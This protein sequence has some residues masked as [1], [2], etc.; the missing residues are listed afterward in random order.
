MTRREHLSR[1]GRRRGQ[2]ALLLPG[3]VPS[4]SLCGGVGRSIHAARRWSAWHRHVR[5]AG[6]VNSG[7][8]LALTSHCHP[9]RLISTSRLGALHGS[10]PHAPPNTSTLGCCCCCCCP[11]RG[12]WL[13]DIGRRRWRQNSSCGRR[14]FISR[15]GTD[16]V[17]MFYVRRGGKTGG[18]K[19]RSYAGG[20]GSSLVAGMI[21]FLQRRTSR[22]R[23]AFVRSSS[24]SSG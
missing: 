19:R 16:Q 12:A 24:S 1:R 9:R 6:G 10:A 23:N 14:G 2:E 20:R 8:R 13:R 5:S 7:P 21:L 11:T 3:G 15:R 17:I 18:K 4:Q 22:S